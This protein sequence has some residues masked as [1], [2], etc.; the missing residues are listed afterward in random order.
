[1]AEAPAQ[2]PAET[3]VV[4]APAP[5]AVQSPPA[6]KPGLLGNMTRRIT[7]MFGS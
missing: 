5:V 1:A 3:A 4:P 6:Q 2:T 7:N